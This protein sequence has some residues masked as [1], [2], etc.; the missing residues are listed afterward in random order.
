MP[1][2]PSHGKWSRQPRP[3]SVGW[4]RLETGPGGE[5]YR[6]HAVSADRAV[7]TYRCPGCDQT[8]APGVAHV[9]TWPSDNGE[10]DRRHWHTGCWQARHTRNTTR[11]RY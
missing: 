2:R 6:V 8:I 3:L 4:G 10:E 9:V 7:K 11:R 5:Q 1:R